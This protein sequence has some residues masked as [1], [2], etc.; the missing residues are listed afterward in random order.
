MGSEDDTGDLR[1]GERGRH[2]RLKGW[3]V[4]TTL[5]ACG[6]G[7]EDDSGDLVGGE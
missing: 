7:S 6:V 3:G 1:A 5:D 4:E 2:W